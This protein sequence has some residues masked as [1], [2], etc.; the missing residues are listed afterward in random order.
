MNLISIAERG[1]CIYMYVCICVL[2][3]HLGTFEQRF[4]SHLRKLNLCSVG[5]LCG[6]VQS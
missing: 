5:V 1:D 3:C 2:T 6:V 4:E